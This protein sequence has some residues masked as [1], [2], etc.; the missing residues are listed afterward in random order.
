MKPLKKNIKTSSSEAN[1]TNKNVVLLIAAMSSFIT[2]FTSSSVNIA[3]PSI[4]RSL[5]LNAI[6]LSWIATAYLLAAAILLVPFGRIADIHGRKRTF[7]FG[8]TIDAIASILCAVSQSGPWLIAFRAMQG[9]GGA[10]IFGTGVAILT[11]VFPPHER[12]RALGINAAAVYSGLSMG[13]LIGG[14]LTGYLGWRSIFLLNAFLA[15]FVIITVLWKLKGEWA[16]AKGEKF[17]YKGAIIYSLAMVTLMTGLSTLPGIKGGL[18]I[19]SG[20]CGI[21]VFAWWELRIEQPVLNI[22]LFQRNRVFRYSNLAALINYSATYAVTFLLSLYLQYIKGF[23]PEHAGMVM[24]LQPFMQ[25]VCSPIAG[26]LS[27]RIEP[28][29][30]ASVGMAL[31]V[32]GLLM[33]T[34][35]GNDTRLTFIM[36]ALVI[37]GSGFGFFSSPNI[38]AVMSSVDRRFYGVASGT[39]STMRLTGQM[40]SMGMN[41]LL[42]SLYIGPVQI[43]PE[44]Y[45][46]FLICLKIVFFISAGFC[47][48]GIFASIARGKT[49]T[50]H[51][52]AIGEKADSKTV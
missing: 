39:L 15:I 11:S 52:S 6:E 4:D 37:L 43:T 50:N 21:A 19:L 13:P 9:L 42:F 35:L 17:D 20:I 38:N 44:K 48:T 49:H 18:L 23:T 2:P 7:L 16:G 14:T 28:R 26:S 45:P 5:S 40:F 33:L 10:M 46:L 29:I 24:M 34:T 30:L 1:Q 8:M 25:I 3:L 41:L 32:A 36:L 47:F 22:G 31:T 51:E 12:G 27:D